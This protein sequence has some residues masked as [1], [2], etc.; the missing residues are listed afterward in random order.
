MDE[1]IHRFAEEVQQ[2]L[3]VS[4][5]LSGYKLPITIIS[6]DEI[7][8]KV[9]GYVSLCTDRVSIDT[10]IIKLHFDV[11]VVK[12]ASLLKEEFKKELNNSFVRRHPTVT[13]VLISDP[14]ISIAASPQHGLYLT[15]CMHSLMQ[16][17]LEEQ[18]TNGFTYGKLERYGQFKPFSDIEVMEREVDGS[19]IRG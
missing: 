3:D 10:Y 11:A 9:G 17:T 4:D 1:L 14:Q 13:D 18:Y 12:T 8:R 2:K 16:I 19:F 7:A 5:C 6:Q 15:V